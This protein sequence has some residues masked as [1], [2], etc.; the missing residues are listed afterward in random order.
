MS[1]QLGKAVYWMMAEHTPLTDL[2]GDRIYQDHAPQGL[3]FRPMVVWQ[4][5][6]GTPDNRVHGVRPLVGHLIQVDTYAETRQK[7][8]EVAE[9]VYA[10]I[11]G[12][13]GSVHGVEV[14]AAYN[15]AEVEEYSP[16]Q[17]ADGVG[18]YRVRQDYRVFLTRA[19]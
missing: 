4:H 8:R 15:Q 1:E 14:R 7:S 18:V 2:V 3:E 12:Y 10:A 5:I 17:H 16:P 11:D 6:D 13:I 9:A 19:A